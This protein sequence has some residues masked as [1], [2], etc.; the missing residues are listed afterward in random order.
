MLSAL[1]RLI[2]RVS[3]SGWL[4]AATSV[5]MVASLRT[6]IAI[7]EGFP[8]VAGGAPPFDLQNALTGPEVLSQL[9]AYGA[10]ARRQ[11]F[12]FTAIDYLFPFA[13]GLFLAAI[14]AFCLRRSFP[15]TYASL[16][17]R[18][19]LPVFMAGSLFDWGE[20]VAAL[21]AIL[22]YPDT[23]TAVATALV[24]AKRLKLVLVIATQSLALVLLAVTAGRWVLTRKRPKVEA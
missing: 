17:G 8:A 12:L 18:R 10:E 23:P 19:L 21:T 24:V 4:F 11:Y 15:S 1:H 5:V 2:V 13:A 22:S 3:A 16:D 14:I 20:N 6:L 7:G 9:G